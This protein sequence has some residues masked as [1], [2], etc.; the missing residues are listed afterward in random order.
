MIVSWLFPIWI[1]LHKINTWWSNLTNLN[2]T[3]WD[4]FGWSVQQSICGVCLQLSGCLL[5]STV[6]LTAVSCPLSA[7]P[8]PEIQLPVICLPAAAGTL[9][10]LPQE[11]G[12]L[13]DVPVGR[14]RLNSPTPNSDLADPHAK[15][16]LEDCA[17]VWLLRAASELTSGSW[18]SLAS[19]GSW[20]SLASLAS[21]WLSLAS[22]ACRVAAGWAA[23]DRGHDWLLNC[24]V[25]LTNRIWRLELF[26][27]N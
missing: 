21:S 27:A 25:I 22:L 1:N 7:A 18:L 17:A 13:S 19:L 3:E 8:L 10:L 5:G 11:N 15:V 20:L 12:C 4:C 14:S 2:E 26:T 24:C 9:D 6:A 16:E 23:E